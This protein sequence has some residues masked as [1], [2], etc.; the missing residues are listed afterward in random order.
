MTSHTAPHARKLLFRGPIDSIDAPVTLRTPDVPNH[1]LRVVEVQV[2]RGELDPDDLATLVA[3]M[4]AV[5]SGQGAVE[6]RAYGVEVA[7]IGVVAAVTA[8]AI[9]QQVIAAGVAARCSFMA[10]HATEPQALQVL[11]VGHADGN[12][13]GRVDDGARISVVAASGGGTPVVGSSGRG[14]SGYG[15]GDDDGHGQPQ[16]PGLAAPGSGASVARWELSSRRASDSPSGRDLAR[17]G[18]GATR[19]AI[20]ASR[21]TRC[22]TIWLVVCSHSSPIREPAL[23]W[24]PPP[25][26]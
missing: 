18:H 17:L 15:D 23:G 4:A 9:G 8:R 24:S 3:Q 19:K 21:R 25:S 14:M 10:I 7:V 16:S 13:L 6:G 1:V 2:G 12:A 26:T 22:P 20:V 5:A 11:G